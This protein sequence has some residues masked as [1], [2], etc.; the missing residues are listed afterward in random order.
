MLP[1]FVYRDK[2]CIPIAYTLEH[3][4]RLCSFLNLQRK[5]APLIPQTMGVR[6]NDDAGLPT[7]K[8]G[9]IP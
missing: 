1:V 3:H 7:T 5:A 8:V 2:R 9:L 4:K 6:K